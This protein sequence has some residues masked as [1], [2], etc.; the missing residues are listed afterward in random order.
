MKIL[1]NENNNTISWEKNKS[2]NAF[3]VVFA[4]FGLILYGILVLVLLRPFTTAGVVVII[5]CGGIIACAP[6]ISVRRNIP[7]SVGV[8]EEGVHLK[9][10][11]KEE[12]IKLADVIRIYK[13][14]S[15]LET[16][17]VIFLRRGEIKRISFVSRKIIE[18]IFNKVEIMKAQKTLQIPESGEVSWQTNVKHNTFLKIWISIP[19]ILSILC[20]V[21]VT[22]TYPYASLKMTIIVIVAYFV[23]ISEIIFVSLKVIPIRIGFSKLGIHFKYKIQ[24]YEEVIPWEG[25]NKVVSAKVFPFYRCMLKKDGARKEMI[26]ICKHVADQIYTRSLVHKL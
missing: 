2:W 22:I 3:P 17:C 6:F 12:T 10:K 9:F 26:F 18:T 16:R 14:D 8:S 20:S 11:Q 19:I 7:L 23:A 5:L 24:K 25:I 15:I 13:V 4:M 21:W 1:S